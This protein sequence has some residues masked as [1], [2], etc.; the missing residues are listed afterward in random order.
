MN[1]PKS[2]GS[3]TEEAQGRAGR[4]EAGAGAGAGMRTGRIHGLLLQ[5]QFRDD[6]ASLQ[7]SRSQARI[8]ALLRVCPHPNSRKEAPN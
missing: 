4:V 1:G 2:S 6:S 7:A 8:P 3:Q 5:M